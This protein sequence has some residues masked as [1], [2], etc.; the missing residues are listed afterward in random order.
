MLTLLVRVAEVE[1][2]EGEAT[3]EEKMCVDRS[4]SGLSGRSKRG[5]TGYYGYVRLNCCQNYKMK[6]NRI[7]SLAG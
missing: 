4:G 5:K 6:Q 3:V 2:K 7:R 1:G